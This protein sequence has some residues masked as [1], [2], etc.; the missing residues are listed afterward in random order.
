MMCLLLL[1]NIIIFF[2]LFFLLLAFS[3]FFIKNITYSLLIKYKVSIRYR[4]I[5][6]KKSQIFYKEF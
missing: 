6:H 4:I 2:N 1:L 5:T 3:F